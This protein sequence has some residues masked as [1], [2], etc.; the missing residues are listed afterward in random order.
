MGDSTKKRD[1]TKKTEARL[2]R[3][4]LRQENG[5]VSGTGYF[6]PEEYDSMLSLYEEKKQEL[7]LK[8]MASCSGGCGNAGL[9]P[10]LRNEGI[11]TFD[12]LICRIA[13]MEKPESLTDTEWDSLKLLVRRR[14]ERGHGLPFEKRATEADGVERMRF[15]EFRT[16]YDCFRAWGFSTR[17]VRR[18]ITELHLRDMQALLSAAGTQGVG[19]DWLS[20]T[21]VP[22]L[23]AYS[24]SIATDTERNIIISYDPTTGRATAC[25]WD[26]K[27]PMGKRITAYAEGRYR[28]IWCVG[29]HGKHTGG[30]VN[31]K[32]DNQ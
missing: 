24:A 2:M 5:A 16:Q 29:G 17:Q 6:T 27:P 25:R 11:A 8:V 28:V 1:S 20:E 4:R 32:N 21:S 15:H 7:R 22:K 13:N 9:I 19:P 26:G 18:F 30:N 12:D 31:A 23:G 14:M 10:K 3:R